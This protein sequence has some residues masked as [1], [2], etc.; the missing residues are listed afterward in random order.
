M[1]RPPTSQ[2]GSRA[3]RARRQE[4]RLRHFRALTLAAACTQASAEAAG[5]EY[6]GELESNA[7]ELAARSVLDEHRRGL[8]TDA[9]LESLGLRE[10]EDGSLWIRVGPRI[11]CG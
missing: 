5:V 6:L 1:S 7:F 8:L 3:R 11:G 4:R 9:D 10:G 2:E